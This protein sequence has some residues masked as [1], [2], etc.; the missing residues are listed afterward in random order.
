MLPST[1]FKKLYLDLYVHI[2]ISNNGKKKFVC[3]FFFI[4]RMKRNRSRPVLAMETM[5]TLKFKA[6]FL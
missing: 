6:T 3:F 2:N 5:C 4:W 1:Q